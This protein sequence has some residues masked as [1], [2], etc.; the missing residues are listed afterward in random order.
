MLLCGGGVAW[1]VPYKSRAEQGRKEEKLTRWTW[2]I[3]R[4]R[5]AAVPCGQYVERWG[6]F[7]LLRRGG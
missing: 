3:S 5:A 4:Q 1:K 7:F 6:F 2:L